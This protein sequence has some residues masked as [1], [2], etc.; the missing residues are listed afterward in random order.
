MKI[1]IKTAAIIS[2]SLLTACASIENSIFDLAISV[3]R[4]FANLQE[5]RIKLEEHEWVYL[6]ANADEGKE[7]VLLLHGFA[8]EKDNWTR[9]ADSLE[10][11]HVIAPDLPGHGESSFDSD[12]FYG[13]D[14]QSLRLARF[15]DALGLKQFHI[16]GNSMGGGIA[17][18]YAYRH[19][20]RILSLGLIDAVGFYG[21]EPS[22]LEIVLEKN[23]DNPLIVESKDDFDR[24]IEYA[25]HQ[26]PFMPWPAK[27]VLTRKAMNRTEANK[28]IFEHIHKE[29]EA[30]K[31]AGGF[32]HV[33]EQ[34]DMPTLVLWGEKDR[35]LDVSSVD[36]FFQHTPNVE[37]NVL[38]DIGHAPMLE[39]PQQTA[40]ILQDFWQ[41][42]T[43]SKAKLASNTNE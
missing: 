21:N 26:P 10:D 14:V 1:L 12:L 15:V 31:F 41:R 37:V 36:K 16:V 40:L 5:K 25:M 43:D 13:F 4:S 34:L 39:V 29:A 19:P 27:S 30:A 8:A 7:T 22:D 42:H 24:L 35:V 38:L 11:Y 23:L 32:V 18:L 2:L 3:E 20:H 9:M 17:A 6:E 33:F 28:H